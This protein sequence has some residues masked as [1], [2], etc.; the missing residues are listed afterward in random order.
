MAAGNGTHKPNGSHPR[1]LLEIE[2]PFRAAARHFEQIAERADRDGRP[3][4]S[5]DWRA[6]AAKYAGTKK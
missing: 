6:W 1:V 4:A 5:A 2:S 3:R